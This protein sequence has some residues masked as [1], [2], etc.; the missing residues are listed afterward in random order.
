[1]GLQL[2][3]WVTASRDNGKRPFIVVDKVAAE[4]LVFDAH[5]LLM[6][7]TP[8][9]VG[10]AHGDGA[11]PGVGDKELSEIGPAEKT[12]PAGRYLARI[13]PAKGIQ[14]VLWVDFSTSVALH[15]I[16]TTNPKEQRLARLRS[17]T[18]NDNRITFGCINVSPVFFDKLVLPSFS[19]AGGMVYI[20]PEQK[21]LIEVFPSFHIFLPPSIRAAS[22]NPPAM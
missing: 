7:M 18:R 3:R 15:P 1:M 14:K 13:G 12:T 21:F 22:T 17:A 10:I 6:G 5:G 19:K 9:L 16:I 11:T 8:A 4:V 20:L 2:A